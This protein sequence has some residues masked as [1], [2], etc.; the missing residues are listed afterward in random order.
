MRI[1]ALTAF[2]FAACASAPFSEGEERVVIEGYVV[3]SV[4]EATLAAVEEVAHPIS[5]IR[6]TDD[7]AS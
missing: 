7:E 5:V 6:V 1:R 4:R 3:E 2:V